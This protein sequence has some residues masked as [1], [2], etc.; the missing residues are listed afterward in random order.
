[1]EEQLMNGT[2]PRTAGAEV[3]YRQAVP[4]D[5]SA[6]M[7]LMPIMAEEIAVTPVDP[8]KVKQK[9]LAVIEG[10]FVINA[11][12]EGEL[13]GSLGIV[14][15]SFW[16]SSEPI[17]LELWTFVAP[18]HRHSRVVFYL[19]KSA[20]QAAHLLGMKL[21]I[22][23]HGAN[24]LERLDTLYRHYFSPMGRSYISM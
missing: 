7:R 2:S 13:V 4:E 20:K 12:L 9:M 22:G 6:M 17:M 1:M 18:R 11:F 3:V 24:N 23:A 16:Y 14:K 10:G 5:I 19:L 8:E 21:V 15:D